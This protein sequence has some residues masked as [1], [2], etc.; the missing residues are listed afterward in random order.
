MADA[1][2]DPGIVLLAGK[3]GPWMIGQD[4]GVRP[5][6][7]GDYETMFIA[8]A[9]DCCVLAGPAPYQEVGNAYIGRALLV[10]PYIADVMVPGD[11][12]YFELS[13]G[14]STCCGTPV[15]QGLYTV[16]EN[17]PQCIELVQVDGLMHPSLKVRATTGK[18]GRVLRALPWRLHLIEC[19]TERRVTFGQGVTPDTPSP[20]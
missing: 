5:L 17:P 12:L 9:E 15:A 10:L 6:T 14:W 7:G 8:S 16:P 2:T 20:P 19:C 18:T 4:H 13:P 3:T 1:N 11:T